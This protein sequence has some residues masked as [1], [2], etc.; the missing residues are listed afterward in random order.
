MFDS[1]LSTYALAVTAASGAVASAMHGCNTLTSTKA[2]P[3]P[4]VLVGELV[5]TFIVGAATA[6]LIRA[7]PWPWS[8]VAVLIAAAVTGSTLGPRG[9][10][11]LWTAGL[12][13]VRKIIPLLS[14]LPDAP[15]APDAPEVTAPV[16]EASKEDKDA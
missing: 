8:L 4:R 14:G 9:L 3:K 16:V 12:G 15:P 1:T 5:R 2:A 13:V 7:L 10:T 6:E 11:W